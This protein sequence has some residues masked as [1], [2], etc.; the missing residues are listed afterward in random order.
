MKSSCLSD[1]SIIKFIDLVFDVII[2]LIK[3]GLLQFGIVEQWLSTII[4]ENTNFSFYG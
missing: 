2:L 3:D 1:L 4:Y